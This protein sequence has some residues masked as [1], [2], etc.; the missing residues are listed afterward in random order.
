M[1]TTKLGFYL[2]F[3]DNMTPHHRSKC[4]LGA[5][6]EGPH[7]QI[8]QTSYRCYGLQSNSDTSEILVQKSY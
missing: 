5:L 2:C 7:I 6:E 4:H 1:Q 8:L 3:Q